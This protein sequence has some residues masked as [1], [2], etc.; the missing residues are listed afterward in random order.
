MKVLFSSDLHL[1][2]ELAEE[3]IKIA[4]REDV[5]V[6]VNTGDFL[7][8]DFANYFAK[9]IHDSGMIGYFVEGNWDNNIEIKFD[10]VKVLRY[11][12]E[13]YKRFYF[14]GVYEKVLLSYEDLLEITKHINNNKLIFLTH[15][16]PYGI[17]DI[18][19]SGKSIGNE[20]YL[21]F[22]IIKQPKIHAF[23]HV[24]EG[25]GYLKKENTLFINA[26]M[27]DIPFCYVV[28]LKNDEIKR[29]KAKH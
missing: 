17:L 11:T 25:N 28:D 12:C 27:N 7:S 29:I 3:T 1:R 13:K 20:I 22:D 24:H 9:L 23:G 8:S 5:E 18:I 6:V 4:L 16:P 26:A 21:K 10:S 2:K 19:W 15:E 14:F